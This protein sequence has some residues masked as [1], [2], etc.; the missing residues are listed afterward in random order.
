LLKLELKTND[1]L[2]SH[3]LLAPEVLDFL[4]GT[5]WNVGNNGEI[6]SRVKIVSPVDELKAVIKVLGSIYPNLLWDFS[7]SRWARVRE[8]YK[9]RNALVHP[10]KPEDISI[11]KIEIYAFETFRKDFNSWSASIYAE[12]WGE[13]E[14]NS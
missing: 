11:T 5:E 1:H 14:S 2:I 7:S 10:K 4:D 9:T 8:L 12:A 6:K 13:P 3:S